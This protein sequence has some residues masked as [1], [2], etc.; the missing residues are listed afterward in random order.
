[1]RTATDA[2]V[3]AVGRIE[4]TID[5]INAIAGSIAA[6]V[7]QQGAATA[8]I[9]RNVSETASAANEMSRRIGEVSEEAERT[10]QHSTQVRDGTAALHD[11]VDELKQS[12][13]R[14]VRTST[15]EV[16]RRS[17][18]RHAVNLPC[19]VT[20]AGGGMQPATIIDLSMGG[21]SITGG[22]AVPAGTRGSLDAD[23][24][25]VPLP[26]VVRSAAG[27]TLHIQFDLDTATA[28]RYAQAFE[29]VVGQRAA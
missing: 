22:P 16:D 9:A 21:A 29:R 25:G 6:A 23:R 26:F 11:L 20:V 10:G 13:I 5:E 8:E 3:A 19:R 15:A 4:K 18:L 2:S 27:G 24:V 12:V 17:A 7:E 1:V 28:G 14:V